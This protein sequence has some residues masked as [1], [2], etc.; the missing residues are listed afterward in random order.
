MIFLNYINL[1][2]VSEECALVYLYRCLIQ[3]DE[4]QCEEFLDSI[5]I[6]LLSTNAIIHILNS[7]S[8]KKDK[9]KNW[10]NFVFLISQKLIKTEGEEITKDLLKVIL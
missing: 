1:K 9:I 2:S 4:K 7:I 5:K 8:S 3:L 10:E 6:E